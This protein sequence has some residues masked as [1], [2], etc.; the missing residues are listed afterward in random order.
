MSECGYQQFDL[1]DHFDMFENPHGV[2]DLTE[3]D[4]TQLQILYHV[5]KISKKYLS[6]IFRTRD[7]LSVKLNLLL[8]RPK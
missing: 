8:V 6:F 4:K 2:K 1:I 7:M 5:K 3:E